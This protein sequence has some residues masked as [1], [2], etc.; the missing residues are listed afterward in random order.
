LQGVI[1][2]GEEDKCLEPTLIGM[3]K[4]NNDTFSPCE[5]EILEKG[6]IT[7]LIKKKVNSNKS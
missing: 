5:K 4:H 7:N 2:F 1:F 3:S 6:N